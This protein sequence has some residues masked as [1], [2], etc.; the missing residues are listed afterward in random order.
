MGEDFP[1]ASAP[2]RREK[3]IVFFSKTIRNRMHNGP[4]HTVLGDKARVSKEPGA[5]KAKGFDPFGDLPTYS[6]KY[7]RPLRELPLFNTRTYRW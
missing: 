5:G 6:Q 4:L 3:A 7:K 2:T 1:V